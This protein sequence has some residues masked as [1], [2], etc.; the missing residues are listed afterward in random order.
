MQSKKVYTVAEA[1][2][3]LEHF[4]AY[5]E[6]THREVEQ[7]LQKMGM[8]PEVQ[9]QIII[10]LIQENYLNEERFAR[11]FARGKF[12]QND[13]GRMKITKALYTKGV[14]K[15]NIELGMQEIDPEAYTIKLKKLSL[16][17]WESLKGNQFAK[18]Q[19]VYNYLMQKGYESALI[20]EVLTEYK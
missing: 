6:R 13:W 20:G 19:K 3:A 11:N 15:V 4:C 8:I 14:S 10:H 12:N 1:K 9:E 17:K 16:K 5:Q 7:K 2:A 18:K